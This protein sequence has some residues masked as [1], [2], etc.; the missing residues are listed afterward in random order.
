MLRA[1][2]YKV[3]VDGI[4]GPETDAALRDFQSQRGLRPD[5]KVGRQT[6]GAFLFT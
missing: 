2:G 4:F 1:K 3:K 6:A 5:G